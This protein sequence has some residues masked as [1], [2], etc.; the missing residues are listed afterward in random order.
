MRRRMLEN[1]RRVA[2]GRVPIGLDMPI[3]YGEIRAE[4]AVVPIDQP[5]QTVGPAATHGLPATSA[6]S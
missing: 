3:E 1:V 4:Q 5:W 6:V 2:D